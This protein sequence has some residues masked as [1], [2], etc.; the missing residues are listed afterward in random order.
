MK[1]WN[2]GTING[3]LEGWKNGT[4]KNKN[5]GTINGKTKNLMENWNGGRMEQ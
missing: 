5:N 1:N 4:M 2:N 3:K